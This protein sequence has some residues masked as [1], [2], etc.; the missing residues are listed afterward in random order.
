[1]IPADSCETYPYINK[2]A[3][4]DC[5]SVLANIGK[6][7]SCSNDISHGASLYPYC[8]IVQFLTVT[9]IK[10]IPASATTVMVTWSSRRYLS[11]S[12]Q[13]TSY[14]SA[15]GAVM[16][17]SEQ[18]LPLGV[19]TTDVSLDDEIDGYKHNFTLH[20]VICDIIPTPTTTVSFTFGK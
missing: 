7:S 1:M 13:Y 14:F 15:T 17:Q 20:Y 10:I 6:E 19:T 4:H 12:L 11:T 2:Q 8:F 16:S 9:A 18:V 5:A 3:R